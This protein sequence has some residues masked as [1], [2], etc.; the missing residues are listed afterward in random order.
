MES[1]PSGD[2]S[3]AQLSQR[4]GLPAGTLR[5][6]E[7]RY[8]F[9]SARRRQGRH[10]RY[11]ERDVDSVLE[12]LRMRSRGLS[13]AAAIARVRERTDDPPSSI[14]AGLR[15]R[16]PE[17]QPVVLVKPAVL[18]LTR[19]IEDEYLASGASG[20]LIASF[21]RVAFYRSSERRWRELARTAKLTVALADFDVVRQ[22]KDGPVEVPIPRA[23]ALNREWALIVDAPPVHACVAALEQTSA[24]P[25]PDYERRFEV[26]WSF[27]PGVVA[28][29]TRV[30]VEL[31]DAFAP[32]VAGL[33]PGRGDEPPPGSSPELRFATGLAHRVVAYL[34]SGAG[35]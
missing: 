31:V 29:A 9:P 16:R 33:L 32:A 15:Q 35:P 11:G 13:L 19:A 17:V 1:A 18:A 10:R 7:S 4:T 6:W 3:T 25:L 22:P 5:M 26:L 24:V 27:D 14:F 28:A 2:L 8:G 23:H 30:A 34:A 12:V 21:Q 20:L